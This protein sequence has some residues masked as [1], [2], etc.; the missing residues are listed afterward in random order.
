VELRQLRHFVAV[1]ETGN[2]TRAASRIP[3]S[4]PALTRSIR[5]LE[6]RMRVDLLERNPRGVTPTAAGVQLYKHA[7]IVLNEC[8]RITNEMSEFRLG[9][10]GSVRIGIAAMFARYIIDQVA[11]EI[12]DSH[13]KLAMVIQLGLFE[14]LVRDLDEGRL[15]LVFSN[16]PPVGLPSSLHVEVL[17]QVESTVV[18]NSR[19]PLARLKKVPR[20]E[21]VDAKWVVIDQPHAQ[22]FI[23][24]FF[25]GANLPKPTHVV[26]TNSLS[27][28]QGL[29]GSGQ[30]LS[31]VPVHLVAEQIEAGTVRRMPVAEGTVK[32]DA[33]LLSR[34]DVPLPVAAEPVIESLRRHAHASL[35]QE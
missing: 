2:L 13:P 5:N 31:V 24:T 19:H 14:D 34:R 4:Q 15:D 8:S 11:L 30:F 25:S 10:G 29:I 17:G 27:L 22:D 28:I 35:P 1:V 21:L 26:R 23:D 9:T 3:I 18:A 6:Q 12:A 16:L 32:R 33:A 7:K 20:A